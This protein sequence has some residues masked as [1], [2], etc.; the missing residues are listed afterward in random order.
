MSK[1]ISKITSTK[2]ANT[3]HPIEALGNVTAPTGDIRVEKLEDRLNPKVPFPH[4]HDF[5]QLVFISRGSGW[6]QL[7]FEKYKAHAGAFFIVKP[8]QMHHWKLDSKTMGLIIEFTH[9]SLPKEN[10]WASDLLGKARTL[11]D[12][13]KLSSTKNKNE[14]FQ[15]LNFML[16]EFAK[17]DA[18]FQVCLQNYLSNL[19][20]Q[21]LRLSKT[22]SISL[23]E[24]DSTIE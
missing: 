19:L 23:I 6:H 3:H 21:L 11:P 16:N 18:S 8:G 24:T 2:N 22:N 15:I 4:K 13:I 10:V 9:E 7:D 5:F 20:I 14:I 17:R 1:R 12:L